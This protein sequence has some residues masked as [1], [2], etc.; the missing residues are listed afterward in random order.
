[1][2]MEVNLELTHSALHD[3]SLST[4]NLNHVLADTPVY[5]TYMGTSII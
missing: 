1:M 3:Y 4:M 2:I 5:Y